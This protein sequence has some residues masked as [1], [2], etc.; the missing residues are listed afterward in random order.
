MPAIAK[1]TGCG[2]YQPR[3][4]DE[5]LEARAVKRLAQSHTAMWQVEEG[6]HARLTLRPN[7]FPYFPILQL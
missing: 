5:E 1:R 3:F 2:F 4:T 6:T 7:S